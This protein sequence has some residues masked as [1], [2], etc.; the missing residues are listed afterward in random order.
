MILQLYGSERAFDS[1][2]LQLLEDANGLH[3]GE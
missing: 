3:I 1:H 2:R